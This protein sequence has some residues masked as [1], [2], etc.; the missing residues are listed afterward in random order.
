MITG[1]ATS[2]VVHVA[3][4]D[5]NTLLIGGGPSA[6]PLIVRYD[7]NDQYAVG[8][9]GEEALTSMAA[10][11]EAL[12]NDEDNNDTVAVTSFDPADSSDVA[13]FVLTVV[14]DT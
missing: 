10:F 5:S 12:A 7:D 9:T 6:P 8:A 13:R 2:T 3:D 1:L 11:E 14:A 4:A